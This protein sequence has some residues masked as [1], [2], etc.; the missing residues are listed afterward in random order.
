MLLVQRR[1]VSWKDCD[2]YLADALDPRSISWC[3]FGPLD[4]SFFKR[5]MIISVGFLWDCDFSFTREA[6]MLRKIETAEKPADE[7]KT[8]C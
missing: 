4:L 8:M 7:E 3:S 6:A 1:A 5:V 2:Y